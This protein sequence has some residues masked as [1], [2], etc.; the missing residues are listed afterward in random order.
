[1]NPDALKATLEADLRRVAQQQEAQERVWLPSQS[2]EQRWTA[3]DR[4]N[5]EYQEGLLLVRR[6]DELEK[7]R[8]Q[9]LLKGALAIMGRS[10]SSK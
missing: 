10:R 4:T 5:E 7:K 2:W 1:M 9:K 6:L 3:D 8:A